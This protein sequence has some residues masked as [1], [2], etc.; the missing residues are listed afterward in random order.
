MPYPN[1]DAYRFD[2]GSTGCLLIH[3][4]GGSPEETHA[5]GQHLA[6][7]GFTVQGVRLAGHG[8]AVS[9]F[10][11]SHW[12]QWLQ[13][14][15]ASFEDLQ[16]RCDHVVIIGFSLGGVLGLI[17]ASGHD[18]S[19]LVTLGSRV[20]PMTSASSRAARLRSLIGKRDPSAPVVDE[21]RVAVAQAQTVLRSV[22]VPA[23]LMQGMDDE[24]V[25]TDNAPAIHQ[26]L[27]S[28]DKELRMWPATGHFMLAG[29]PHR[30]EI[31]DCVAGFVRRVAP[32][33]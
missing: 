6:A 26:G 1:V 22:T 2:G 14:A 19:G 33:H 9:D 25:T 7:A 15:T 13:S 5:L 18:V 16:L 4:F 11:A 24:M 23:L 27:A 17:I 12:R 10:H 31:Y 21:L 32:M 28:P 8:G 30:A 3:G 29:G 20:L